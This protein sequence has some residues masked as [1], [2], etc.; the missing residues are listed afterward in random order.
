MVREL[1]PLEFLESVQYEYMLKVYGKVIDYD[2]MY[3]D[4]HFLDF[5]YREYNFRYEDKEEILKSMQ[6]MRSNHVISRYENPYYFKYFDQIIY[7]IH[8]IKDRFLDCEE[9]KAPLFGTVEFDL[10]AAQIREPDSAMPPLILFSSGIIQF[11]HDIT[12]VLTKAFP[13]QY[14]ENISVSFSMETEKALET[15]KNNQWIERRF[16]DIVLCMFFYNNVELC[17]V[18]QPEND[19][20]YR[21]FSNA[22]ADS[23]LTFVVAHECAHYY[24]GHL[25]DTA[26]KEI[27]SV[28]NIK[29]ESINPD[30]EQEF[31]ADNVGAL[32]AIPVLLNK[33]MDIQVALG[34]IYIAL[35]TLSI[36]E[37]LRIGGREGTTT[38][39]PAKD[40]LLNVKEKL[41][42]M[43]DNDLC[44]LDTYDAVFSS[45]WNRF[46]IIS[47]KVEEKLLAGRT[48]ALV[49]YEQV[50]NIIY[51]P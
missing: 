15:I 7:D 28:G 12:N 48:N 37:S 18:S 24:L 39:P 34:G 41:R 9:Q 2:E 19:F 25:K 38:H 35:W 45:L 21:G 29:Y 11:A 26:R 10:F 22:L 32:L 43:L 3:S 50:K 13:L 8:E 1:D 4:E 36:M 30:W 23:F 14:Q 16:S 46:T 33:G 47:K 20:L 27:V 5:L 51:N 44:I 40:R 17:D 42:N 6:K 31:D 49:D